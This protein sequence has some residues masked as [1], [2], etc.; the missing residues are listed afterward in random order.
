MAAMVAVFWL[1]KA[2]RERGRFEREREWRERE[3]REGRLGF[4]ISS[5]IGLLYN[6]ILGLQDY[7]KKASKQAFGLN[8]TNPQ[9]GFNNNQELT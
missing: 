2:V 1:H 8:T 7:N 3:E 9:L 6:Q 4:L 5:V